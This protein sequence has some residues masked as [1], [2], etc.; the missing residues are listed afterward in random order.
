MNLRV[1]KKDIDFFVSEFIDDCTI[2]VALNDEC[3][4][5]KVD[6]IIDEAVELYNNLKFKVNHP[7]ANQKKK[8][9]YAGV[10]KEMFESLD[11]LCEKLSGA[12]SKK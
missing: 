5:A 2:C 12:I 1:I 10:T 7:D 4:I 6:A 8:V 9:Y 3:D 11:E